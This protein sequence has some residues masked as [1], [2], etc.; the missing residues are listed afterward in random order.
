M[1]NHTSWHKS[2]ID[3]RNN[4]D[5]EPP[6]LPHFSDFM[7]TQDITPQVVRLINVDE[8]NKDLLNYDAEVYEGRHD[9][10]NIHLI[11]PYNQQPYHL[12]TCDYDPSISINLTCLKQ[13]PTTII[14]INDYKDIS[15]QSTCCMRVRT[16]EQQVDSG[17]NKSVTDDKN[18]IMNYQP[19]GPEPIFGVEKDQVACQIIGHGIAY[20][21]TIDGDVLGIILYHAPGCAG[22]ILSPNAIVNDSKNFTGWGQ[23]S[24]MDT[25]D[26]T[27]TFFN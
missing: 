13:H 17:A 12:P 27:I 24:H 6:P 11:T 4:P 3:T 5:P 22:T 25:Q 16:D 18:I 15:I 2:P 23:I 26:A 8:H 9:G 10:V 21:D 1:P 19:I 7:S 20:L 14:T